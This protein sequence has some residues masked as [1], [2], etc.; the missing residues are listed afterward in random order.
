AV[1][2]IRAPRS[3]GSILKPFLYASMLDDGQLTPDMLVADVPTQYG[4]YAPK[5]YSQSYDGAVPARRALARSLNVPAVRMLQDY[6]IDRFHHRL[7]ALGMSTLH[8]PPEDY[9]LSLILGGAEA[10]LWDLASIYAGMGRTLLQYPGYTPDLRA[11]PHYRMHRPTQENAGLE[12]VT[13]LVQA[14]AVWHTLEAMLEV[15]RPEE[16]INWRAFASSRKIAWKTGTSFGFRDAWAIGLTP[17][18][19]VAVWVGNA[20]GEG[21]PGLVGLEAAAPLLFDVFDRLPHAGWFTPPY[22]N[23]AQVPVCRQSGHRVS[24]WCEHPEMAWL[25]ETALRTAACPYHQLVHLDASATWRVD[26]ECEDVARMVPR[27][28]FV[29]PPV[30][31]WYYQYNHPH[32]KSLPPFRADCE[33]TVSDRPMA[34]IYPKRLSR[35]KVPVQLDGSVGRTV[36]QVTH[37][38]RSATIHWH[39]DEIYLGATRDIHEMELVPHPGKHTLTLVDENGQSISR[40]FEVV[41]EAS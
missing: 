18:H 34:V 22:D 15:T 24:E 29:L 38:R 17:D 16:D 21:R 33:A 4:G 19:V 32:Y 31:E 35:I 3:T 13:P 30:M 1:D 9:G 11:K 26:S 37:R 12:A 41:G 5:N 14:G 40:S 23:M 36:F 7:R 6:G 25:P 2:V 10:T 20:D 28:W 39:L 27:S 8:R